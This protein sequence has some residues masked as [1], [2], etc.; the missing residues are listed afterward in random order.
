MPKSHVLR[1]KRN[2][3]QLFSDSKLITS[4]TVNLR[5]A[6]YPN[7]GE[8]FLA[9]FIAPKKIGNAVK[10]T[11]T[12]RLLREAYRLNRHILTDMFSQINAEVHYVFM[13]RNAQLSFDEVQNDMKTLMSKLRSR[14][15]S[16]SPLSQKI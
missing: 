3:D 11:R 14:L 12:K 16:N 7:S 13:A 2:F 8:K 4:P 9:G 15:L 5:F 6:V 10:R 1:G